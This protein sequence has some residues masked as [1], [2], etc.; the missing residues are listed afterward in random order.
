[1]IDA[2][3]IV[4]ALVDLQGRLQG[5]RVSADHFREQVVEHGLPACDYL[6][7]ADVEMEPH[8]PET[9]FGDFVLRPDMATLRP[10]PWHERTACV[11]A[12]VHERGGAPIPHSPRRMLQTQLE[13]LAE[14]GLHA[15]AGTE[16]E[17]LA[18]RE[19]YQQAFERDYRGLTPATRH[20]VDYSI[21]GT[22]ELE[23]LM[24][25]I[26]RELTAAGL[27]LESARG[28]C[29]PG[30]YEIVYRY[31]D[32]LGACDDHVLYKAGAK[33]IAAQEGVALTFMAKYDERGEGSS[34]HVHLSLR[35]ERSEPVLADGLLEPFL[36]GQLACLADFTLLFAPNVNS[37]K[38][39]R[40]G[41]FAPTRGGWG[42]DDRTRAIRVVG[43]GESLRIEHR[44]P[45]ADAN[46]H[47]AVAAMLAAGLHGIE[48]G[49]TPPP[50]GEPLPR[51]LAEAAARFETSERAHAAFGADVVAHYVRAAR[52]ELAA[53]EG[54]V[55]DWERRRG[56]ERL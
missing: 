43:A 55:T 20:N 39:L 54:A 32:A 10:L 31:R 46:P 30:Q 37:Y 28:E 1:M 38:R 24:R 19:S 44:V 21:A 4:V 14:R 50:A 3:E 25:R 49:L 52:H 40:P 16:L 5:S 27:R 53:F 2:D 34:C 36:A 41:T 29:R 8:D 15:L 26:R 6:L 7:A 56:F 45:G 9:A 42:L 11:L 12:D 13:R 33:A 47:V 51:T 23:P 35:D 48:R 22:A 17:L 18:F